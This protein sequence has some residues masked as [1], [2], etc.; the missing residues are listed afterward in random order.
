MIPRAE[1]SKSWIS[2][3]LTVLGG[4]ELKSIA[5]GIQVL[6]AMV[7]RAPSTVLEAETICPGKYVIIITGDVA[8]VEASLEAGMEVSQGQL[9]DDMFIPNVSGQIA[10]ALNRQADESDWDAVGIIESYSALGSIKAGDLAAKESEVALIEIR[11]T[12]GM[13]GKAYV[14][15]MGSLEAVEAGVEAGVSL[16]EPRNLL[17]SKMIIPRPHPDIAHFFYS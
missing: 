1:S 13:G 2:P 17:C 7:K 11:L 8:S 15:M 4:L 3:D 12:T 9:I 10:P 16:L 6:D 14:K 5:V